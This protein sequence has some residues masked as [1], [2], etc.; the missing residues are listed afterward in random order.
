MNIHIQ[1]VIFVE[2][3]ITKNF[4]FKQNED[5]K[6]IFKRYTEYGDKV[7]RQR[8][9]MFAAPSLPD[10]G[11]SESG[12][13]SM[14]SETVSTSS[15]RLPSM[16]NGHTVPPG[17]VLEEL[18]NG[19]A[20]DLHN[21]STHSA[22][23]SCGTFSSASDG[24]FE[25]NGKLSDTVLSV[26]PLPASTT[27]GSKSPL[28]AIKTNANRSPTKSGVKKKVSLNN[29][30]EVINDSGVQMHTINGDDDVDKEI[31]NILAKDDGNSTVSFQKLRVSPVPTPI[32]F[33]PE[34][35]EAFISSRDEAIRRVLQ[36]QVNVKCHVTS[37]ILK[38]FINSAF[39]GKSDT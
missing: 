28:P 23:T 8:N 17:G 5:P 14:S 15:D 24:V 19:E 13:A 30:A 32:A 33:R 31:Q 38:V 20:V 34:T 26:S 35:R 11:E 3:N 36:G 27:N 6:D 2:N 4:L 18:Q 39:T 12:I 1:Y 9:Q 16:S 25:S 22:D 7:N 10:I 21:T 29:M 37:N